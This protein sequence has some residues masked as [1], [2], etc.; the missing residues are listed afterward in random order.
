MHLARGVR[1]SLIVVLAL[2][3]NERG[4]WIGHDMVEEPIR[5]FGATV[6]YE[7]FDRH[8]LARP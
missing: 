7:Y 3:A 2:E 8:G 5:G 4:D 6:L 1:F